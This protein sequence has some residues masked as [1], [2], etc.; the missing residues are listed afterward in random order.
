LQATSQ[1]GLFYV[2]DTYRSMATMELVDY[3]QHRALLA[4][5]AKRSKYFSCRLER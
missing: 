5:M 2:Y 1:R 3:K 4:N